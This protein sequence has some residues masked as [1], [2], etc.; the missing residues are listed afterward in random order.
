[1]GVIH[2]KVLENIKWDYPTS[3]IEIDLEPLFKD[4]K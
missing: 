1:M 4:F 2:P 3:L